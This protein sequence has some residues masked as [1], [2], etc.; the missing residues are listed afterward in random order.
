VR[1][2]C[3]AATTLRLTVTRCAVS[4]PCAT[5]HDDDASPAAS[6]G[7][8]LS[9]TRCSA[10]SPDAFEARA[11]VCAQLGCVLSVD[12]A[13]FA[14]YTAVE[15]TSVEVRK[16][17]WGYRRVS[18]GATVEWTS[19]GHGTGTT[20]DSVQV[21]WTFMMAVRHAAPRHHRHVT[22]SVGVGTVLHV[23]LPCSAD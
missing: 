23:C 16:D 3:T 14:S 21:V 20:A 6:R 19:A 15:D 5:Q 10:A 11:A 7:I 8:A 18:T 22:E 4:Q 1:R 13:A 2:S 9:P 12:A 17:K